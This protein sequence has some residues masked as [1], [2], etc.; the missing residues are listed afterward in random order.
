MAEKGRRRYP[1]K[2]DR[3]E[4]SAFSDNAFDCVWAYDSTAHTDAKGIEKILDEVKRVLKPEG[5]IYFTL[6]SKATEPYADS[7][8]S[9]QETNAVE[10][11]KNGPYYFADLKD[12]QNLLYDF[13]INQI[14]HVEDC[15]FEN[16][17]KSATQYCIDATLHKI[18]ST[19]DYSHI[20]GTTVKGKIDRPLGSAHPRIPTLVY[21]VNYGF[22]E[23]V[24]APDGAEQDI[25]L[26]GIDYP[27]E[28]FEGE[29]I[30][31]IHRRNDIEDKWIVAPKGKNFSEEEI[32]DSIMFQERFFDIELYR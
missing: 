5:C 8:L 3:Y 29:V 18:G 17:R 25:Y 23:N 16:K 19:P 2:K 6:H 9:G 4:S 31:V 15:E 1:G 30:A 12:V 24:F 14:R 28:A 27:V 21:K 10:Q 32:L 20:I 13:T 7:D 26:M 11:G 22:V